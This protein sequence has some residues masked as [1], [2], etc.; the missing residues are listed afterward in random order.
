MVDK[1]NVHEMNEDE[2]SG[3]TGGMGGTSS[4]EVRYGEMVWVIKQNQCNCPVNEYGVQSGGNAGSSVA[5]Q[6]AEGNR[7]VCSYC[8]AQ[9]ATYNDIIG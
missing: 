4:R 3:V 7:V 9:I 1:M 5:G 2:L 6:A 8:R